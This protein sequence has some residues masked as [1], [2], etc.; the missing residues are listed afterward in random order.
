MS[1]FGVKDVLDLANFIIEKQVKAVFIETS[2]PP[3]SINAVIEACAAK[4]FQ[5]KKGKALY[6]DALGASNS[7]ADT[8]IGMVK[9]NTLNIVEALK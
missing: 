2:I 8:Y 5:L 4:D 1:D 6:S 3:K 7:G 9:T